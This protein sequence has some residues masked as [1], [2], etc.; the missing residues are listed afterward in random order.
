MIKIKDKKEKKTKKKKVKEEKTK[1]KKSMIRKLA[2]TGCI[3]T[4][5]FLGITAN[6]GRLIVVHG[7]EYSEAAYKRQM[8]NQIISPKRG[9]IY[10]VNGNILAMSI[11]VETISVNPGKISYSNK[12]IVENEVIAQGLAEN[13]ELDYN[14]VFEKIANAKSSVVVIAK[15]V[16]EEKA[17]SLKTWL[18]EKKITS[19]VNIDEDTKR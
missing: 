18:G 3:A 8:K 2:I 12:K 14:E 7:Q 5:C 17:E 1:E 6:L 15:K 10:D 9:K 13:L 4:F 19:G 11:A 16:S